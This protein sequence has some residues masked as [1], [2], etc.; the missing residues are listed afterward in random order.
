MFPFL[1]H[2]HLK[3][4]GG[5]AAQPSFPPCALSGLSQDG[6]TMPLCGRRRRNKRFYG[7]TA[8]NTCLRAENADTG[9][10]MRPAG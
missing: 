5:H 10:L 7:C 8:E 4:K 3:P 6:C 1:H 2:G 9:H